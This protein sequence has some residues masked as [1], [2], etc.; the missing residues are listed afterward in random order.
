MRAPADDNDSDIEV[1]VETLTQ[2]DEA[3]NH[4][5]GS[6]VCHV[7]TNFGLENAVVTFYISPGQE[8]VGE[9]PK[10]FA[11]ENADYWSEVQETELMVVVTISPKFRRRC[12]EDGGRDID[13]DGPGETDEA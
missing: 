10:N 4:Q 7:E 2:K 13:T 3:N 9:V 1:V 11:N 6:N 12:E 5:E 8:V